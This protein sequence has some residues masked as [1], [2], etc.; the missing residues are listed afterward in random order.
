MKRLTQV[1]LLVV[2]LELLFYKVQKEVCSQMKLDLDLLQ[3]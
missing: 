2:V 3:T 1:Q